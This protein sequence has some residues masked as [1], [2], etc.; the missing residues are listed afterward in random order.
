MINDPNFKKLYMSE[1]EA[2]SK[3][4]AYYQLAFRLFHER[5]KLWYWNWAAALFNSYWMVYRRMYLPAIVFLLFY[6]LYFFTIKLLITNGIVSDYTL[7]TII[8]IPM[9]FAILICFGGLFTRIYFESL[10][11]EY[12]QNSH[13]RRR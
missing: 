9:S 8:T 13:H 10:K 4:D 5:N 12:E 1:T 2:K 3:S 7:I 11:Q 6:S